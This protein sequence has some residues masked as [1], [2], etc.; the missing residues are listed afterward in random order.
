MGL[1]EGGREGGRGRGQG[2]R[3]LPRGACAAAARD[4]LLGR[5]P[6]P[7]T[8][9]APRHA[10]APPPTPP[11]QDSAEFGKIGKYYAVES[12]LVWD[13]AGQRYLPD[14]TPSYGK[15]TLEEFFRK[16]VKEGLKVGAGRRVLQGRGCAASGWVLARPWRMSTAAPGATRD[17]ADP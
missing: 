3:Q 5:P 14:A 4:R 8:P 9:H 10:G 12:M 1:R 13:E 16:A 17:A 7:L 6:L 15:D 2:V 11:T